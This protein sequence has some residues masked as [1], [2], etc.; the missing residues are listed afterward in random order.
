MYLV[1]EEDNNSR[2]RV[3]PSPHTN[4]WLSHT[5][6]ILNYGSTWCRGRKCWSYALPLP[7]AFIVR[8]LIKDRDNFTFAFLQESAV[9]KK[10]AQAMDHTKS[11]G[12][13]GPELESSRDKNFKFSMRSR[14]A[15]R[16]AGG[17]EN[18]DLLLKQ[19]DNFTLASRIKSQ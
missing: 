3:M 18:V 17:Q 6:I 14:P 16:P 7:H 9:T 4:K 19:R 12:S 10:F 1:A 11:R 15:L 8:L 13:E 2:C 5:I